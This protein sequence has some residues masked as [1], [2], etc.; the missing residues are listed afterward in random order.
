MFRARLVC[1]L[2]AAV[3]SNDFVVAQANQALSAEQ[4]IETALQRNRDF[5][6]AKERLS[7]AQALL[8]QAGIRPAPTVEVEGATGRPLGTVGENEFTV[9]YFKPIETA[10]KRDKRIDVAQTSVD[11]AEAEI[12]ERARQLVFDVRI[13]YIAAAAEQQK[14]TLVDRVLQTNQEYFRLTSARVERGDAAPLEADLFSTELSRTEADQIVSTGR[15]ESA[16]VELKQT[17]GYSSTDALVI[18]SDLR[19]PPPAISLAELQARARK[20]R[21]DLRTATLLVSQAEAEL[22]L[23]QAE[24]R[25]DLTLSARYSH[26]NSSI[27]DAFGLT[28]RGIPTPL[29]DTDNIITAGISIP[30]FSSR[31]NLGNIDAARSRLRAAQLRR[32]HLEAIL[33]LE[34]ESA[35]RRWTAAE[36]AL[37]ILRD[38]VVNRSQQNLQVIRQAYNLGQL[39]MFDVLNEQRRAFDTELSF[40]EAQT[41]AAKAIAELERAI[42]GNL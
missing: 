39:R 31:Q 38:R 21:P 8:R 24:S 9:G 23:A 37:S 3:L 7:E 40:I 25:P 29:R 1:V 42:G 30:L 22:I 17:V 13:R 32:E 16:V 14:L 20:D 12:A 6:A 5:L 11:L 35:F 28:G 27:E 36:R 2:V 15:S 4:L 34:V 19:V 33:N 18:S 41:E 26:R 10:G